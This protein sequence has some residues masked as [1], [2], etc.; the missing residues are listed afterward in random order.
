MEQG[1]KEWGWG[2]DGHQLDMRF[3]IGSRQVE[4]AKLAAEEINQRLSTKTVIGMENSDAIKKAD[5]CVLTVDS[6][7]TFTNP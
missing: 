3:L 4:R 2:K 5:I 6:I 1:R 7:S